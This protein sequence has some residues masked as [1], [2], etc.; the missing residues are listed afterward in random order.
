MNTRQFPTS[1]PFIPLC[2]R[3]VALAF[4]LSLGGVA[5][6]AAANRPPRV[7]TAGTLVTNVAQLPATIRLAGWA[8]DDGIPKPPKLTNLWSQTSGP[9]QGRIANR[10]A[11]NTTVTLDRAGKYRFTLVVGD[12]RAK[13]TAPLNV[14]VILNRP[15][16]VDA[17]RDI[18]V[19]LPNPP[20]DRLVYPT[21]SVTVPLS[22]LV[23]DDGNPVPPGRWTS[24]WS[25]VSGSGSVT[26][27]DRSKPRTDVSFTRPGKYALR[28]EA[29]DGALRNN[30]DLTVTVR[31]SAF[32]CL[33]T[34]FERSQTCGFPG[35]Q[36][37]VYNTDP[38]RTIR[39]TI[40]VTY[41]NLWTPDTYK[42]FT[43]TVGPGE[44]VGVVC[45]DPNTYPKYRNA[46]IVGAVDVGGAGLASAL[47]GVD[48][49]V[50]SDKDEHPP[51][52]TV[53]PLGLGG[54]A[55][56]SFEITV[57]GQAGRR[58]RLESSTDLTHWTSESEVEGPVASVRVELPDGGAASSRFFRAVPVD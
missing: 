7:Y 42:N 49:T 4:T 29:Y 51:T 10:L 52:I 41:S 43:R 57:N 56:T 20:F 38:K 15:P 44:R 47:A 26:F 9:A 17:G 18:V 6:A 55:A 31:P 33:E 27:K 40:R 30:D 8:T 16:E 13:T 14:E 48:S 50:V 25:L 37:W 54:T 19:T 12:G 28:L 1:V 3:L 21:P 34:R 24:T 5:H 53:K 35:T 32:G 58:H 46:N 22:G 11:T 2:T 23:R 45:T 36:L 39:F